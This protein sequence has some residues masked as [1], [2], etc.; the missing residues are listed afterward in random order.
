MLATLA[1]A[2]L[3][4]FTGAVEARRVSELNDKE[5]D[6]IQN[7][8]EVKEALKEL[9]TPEVVAETAPKKV[10][11]P[12]KLDP[13]ADN[14]NKCDLSTQYVWADFSCHD[15]PV[16]TVEAVP[17]R[18]TPQTTAATGSCESYRALVAQYDWN[19][20]T[21]MYAMSKESGCNTNAVG[22]NYVIGGIYAPS[23]GLLQVRT[24]AGRPSCE[25]LKN[26][27]TNIATAYSI[28]LGQ[29][30]SAWSVLH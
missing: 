22:D 18:S 30:Y 16:A 11:K 10:T 24:L 20:D 25:A 7:H 15:K 21:M 9:K 2:L 4:A 17:A 14:P 12:K 23:C 19:V 3:L 6:S 26:P 29:G 1:I 13:V 27:A 8:Q 5:Q 28:W